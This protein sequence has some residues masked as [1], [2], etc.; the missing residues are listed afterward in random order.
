M[1]PCATRKKRRRARHTPIPKLTG[2]PQN[3]SGSTIAQAQ[4]RQIEQRTLGLLRDYAERAWPINE[5]AERPPYASAT[6]N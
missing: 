4:A 5:T 6:A 2:L 1:T 3:N